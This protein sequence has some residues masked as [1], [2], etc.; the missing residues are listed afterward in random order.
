MPELPEVETIKCG[1]LP[2]ILNQT[3]T[4]VLV[5]QPKLRWEIQADI[6][7]KLVGRK[8]KQVSRRAKYLL[9]ETNDGTIIL[10]LGM[11]GSLRILE[12]TTPP[13][14]HDHVDITFANNIMLRFNDPRRFG[15]MLWTAENPE[16]H[17]LL[18][19]LGLEP[20]DKKFTGHYLW[21]LAQNKTTPIKSFIM[22]NKIIVGVGNIYATEAL[23]MANILPTS[24]AKT[25]SKE[26]M[27]E[28][29]KMIKQ[30]LQSA[31]KK[32]G[33]TLKDFVNSEGKPG[34]FVNQLRVYGR[35]GLPC[36]TCQTTLKS[37]I[38]GQRNSVFCPRCQ[39]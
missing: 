26:R 2:H 31:I 5:R 13:K 4:E 17:V 7:E 11:S 16:Q 14:K 6:Q 12:Q 15:A 28:L 25:I 24:P 9:I 34:Y 37:I 38:I 22:D 23:Y 8:V 27:N 35:A 36:L 32:G 39:S 1:I 3:I 20:F 33:T 19:N 30:V 21:Q 10:H 18:K 29:V